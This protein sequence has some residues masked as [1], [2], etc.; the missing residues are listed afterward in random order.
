M[1]NPYDPGAADYA[2]R[3]RAPMEMEVEIRLSEAEIEAIAERGAMA[4]ERSAVLA[5]SEAAER[6]AALDLCAAWIDD[7]E[8]NFEEYTMLSPRRK[9]K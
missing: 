9:D 8:A 1:R 3:N 5:R 6:Q 7:F 4:T 2:R